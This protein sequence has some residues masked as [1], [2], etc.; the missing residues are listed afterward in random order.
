VTVP[1]SGGS[2]AVRLGWVIPWATRMVL[3]A[4]D[5][6]A[7][8]KAA[9]KAAGIGYEDVAGW[10]TFQ[11]LRDSGMPVAQTQ[12]VDAE[13][14]ARRLEGEDRPI[15]LDVRHPPEWTEGTLPGATTMEF[16]VLARGIP[17]ELRARPAITYCASGAR[18]G[19]AASLLERAGIDSVA[20]FPGGPK[21][22]RGSGR[23]LET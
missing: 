17:E 23:R 3:I 10:S 15:V 7:A 1:L 11:S 2:F 20:V 14:V 18:A 12:V 8:R 19:I 16:G 9:V 13:E 6:A 4:D 21:E 5:E 22:W